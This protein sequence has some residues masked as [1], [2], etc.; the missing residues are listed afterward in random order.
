MDAGI[1]PLLLKYTF[2]EQLMTICLTNL[3]NLSSDIGQEDLTEAIE[4]QFTK[5]AEPIL[6]QLKSWK[7]LE[8]E[9]SILYLTNISKLGSV[10]NNVIV[11]EGDKNGYFVELLLGILEAGPFDKLYHIANILANVTSFKEG[12]EHFVSN[13]GFLVGRIEK[14]LFTDI[15]EMRIAILKSLRNCLF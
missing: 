10:S 11:G 12:R 6:L 13:K 15:R 9:L 8:K 1:I 7:G 5:T 3:I 2:K 14:L 4:L